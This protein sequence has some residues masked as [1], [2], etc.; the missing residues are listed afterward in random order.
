MICA[1]AR[2]IV[3]A[4]FGIFF[5]RGVNVLNYA[6]YHLKQFAN[7]FSYDSTIMHLAC[8]AIIDTNFFAAPCITYDRITLSQA[9]ERIKAKK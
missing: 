5:A 2:D 7:D 9:A 4:I 8:R 6:T 3:T 1:G